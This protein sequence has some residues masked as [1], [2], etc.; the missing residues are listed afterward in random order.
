MPVVVEEQSHHQRSFAAFIVMSCTLTTRLLGFLKFVVISAIFGGQGGADILNAVLSIPN[1]LRKLMAE[2]ALSTAF[3]PVLS[4]RLVN[5]DA[6]GARKIARQIQALQ[7]IILLPII[8]IFMVF[9]EH[10]I[11]IFVHF[12][13]DTEMRLAGQLLYW[14][15]PYLLV[16]CLA[17]VVMAVLNSH[18]RFFVAAISPLFFSIAII[19]ST[20]LLYKK[21]G[22]F[23][24]ALGVLLG[25]IGQLAIQYPSYCK[26]GY[27]LL[28]SF[29][30][31]DPGVQAVLKIWGPVL[32]TS[33]VFAINQQIAVFL[34]STL[35]PGSSSALANAVVFFQ[36]PFGVFSASV[37]T[38]YYPQI[39]RY[40]HQNAHEE[41]QES[42]T[43]G[44][45]LLLA[46]LLPCSF[47]LALLSHEI[48][49][50]AFMR[51]AFQSVHVG[52]AARTLV[53]LCWG[54]FFTAGY[55]F[56]QRYFYAK[57]YLKAPFISAFFACFI[58]VILSL[59]LIRTPLGVS[60]LAYANSLAFFISFFALIL[61][62]AVKYKT[63]HIKPLLSQALKI[64]F[65]LVITAI[66][67][68]LIKQ[69][70]GQSWW[71]TGGTWINFLRLSCVGFILLITILIGYKLTGVSLTLRKKSPSNK[72]VA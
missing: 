50:V 49:S 6:Q 4:G 42:L 65:V 33:S 38:V 56:L 31:R 11:K 48:I 7:W 61:V 24:M 71:E 46:F 66:F 32:A 21:L 19:I 59:I 25:G 72:D 60:G 54:M 62:M 68:H 9:N 53:G 40:V 47:V 22:V 17:A 37:N 34:A 18:N 8:I 43:S 51:G 27:S 14:V 12:P 20:L 10:I 13:T 39:T 30:L 70:T 36:L 2:G 26:L 55:N 5:G 67:Y 29:Q 52:L 28:P 16:I 64:I 69:Y 1:N 3:I 45:S 44:L 58:D 35:A 23:S 41:L 15:A 63:I 57:S